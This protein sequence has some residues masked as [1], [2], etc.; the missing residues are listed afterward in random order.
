[1]MPPV[2]QRRAFRLENPADAFAEYSR[3]E[4]ARRADSEDDFDRALYER[5]A[6]LVL[7]RLRRDETETPK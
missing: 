2:P 4:L 7:E 6:A 5:A 3:E 1:M